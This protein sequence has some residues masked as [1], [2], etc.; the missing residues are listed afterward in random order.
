MDS[1]YQTWFIF[2]T[3][4]Y[5]CPLWLMRI[6]MM[7]EFGLNVFV[8]QSFSLQRLSVSAC[9]RLY[10]KVISISVC[11]SEYEKGRWCANVSISWKIN[12]FAVFSVVSCVLWFWTWG[13]D[14]WLGTHWNLRSALLLHIQVFRAFSHQGSSEEPGWRSQRVFA[15]SSVYLVSVLSVCAYPWLKFKG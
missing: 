13:S 3:N 12:F 5:L 9:V 10:C 15:L 8:W 11:V 4:S 7:I 6:I 1:I 14:R 2:N